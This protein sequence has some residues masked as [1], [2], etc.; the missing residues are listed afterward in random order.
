MHPSNVSITA[1]FFAVAS[2]L[3]LYVLNYDTRRL[4]VEVQ[5]KER[6][7]DQARSDVAVLRAERGTLTCPDRIDGPARQLG[8]GPPKPEQFVDRREASEPNQRQSRGNGR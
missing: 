3:L 1:F 2:A 5:M 6:F 7:S 4:E 8:L